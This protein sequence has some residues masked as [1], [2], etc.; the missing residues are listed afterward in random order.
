MRYEGLKAW[1]TLSLAA[2]ESRC[3]KSWSGTL[4]S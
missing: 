2:R 1:S 3:A 4:A